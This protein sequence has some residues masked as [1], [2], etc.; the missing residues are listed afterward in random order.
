MNAMQA[1][2]FLVNDSESSEKDLQNGECSK[3]YITFENLFADQCVEVLCK[4]ST[5]LKWPH[6]LACQAQAWPILCSGR[7]LIGVARTLSGFNS[8]QGLNSTDYRKDM[9]RM[10]MYDI[11]IYIQ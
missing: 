1:C 11:Y 7:D 4:I 6:P 3:A 2:C 8:L 9:I 5:A 10:C